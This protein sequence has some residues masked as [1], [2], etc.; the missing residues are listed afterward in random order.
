MGWASKLDLSTTF[1]SDERFYHPTLHRLESVRAVIEW[2][3]ERISG[4]FHVVVWLA[5]IALNSWF[6]KFELSGK[7]YQMNNMRF[8]SWLYLVVR[9][10]R[11]FALSSQTKMNKELRVRCE[12]SHQYRHTRKS[13]S[14]GTT[15]SSCWLWSSTGSG[16]VKK[17][18]KIVTSPVAARTGMCNCDRARCGGK[19]ESKISCAII[20]SV[21]RN[22]IRPHSKSDRHGFGSSSKGRTDAC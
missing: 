16:L 5:E 14:T 3:E 20:P 15:I 18:S 9:I 2:W 17:F 6:R 11:C 10:F 12:D 4:R 21:T 7:S 13:S 22:S 19:C 1:L 8:R